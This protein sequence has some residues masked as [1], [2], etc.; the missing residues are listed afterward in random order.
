MK[1]KE[2]IEAIKEKYCGKCP[3]HINTMKVAQLQQVLRTGGQ[4]G[5]KRLNKATRPV[6]A[7]QPQKAPKINSNQYQSDIIG[8]RKIIKQRKEVAEK[9]AL[10]FR[11]R[12][13]ARPPMEAPRPATLS[14]PMIRP[15]NRIKRDNVQVGDIIYMPSKRSYHTVTRVTASGMGILNNI[16]NTRRTDPNT[17]NKNFVFSRALYKV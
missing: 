16:G 1:R 4:D 9:T 14:P 11:L 12:P 3:L 5:E 13:K 2:L 10:N 8:K 17:S 6:R 15:A 7:F